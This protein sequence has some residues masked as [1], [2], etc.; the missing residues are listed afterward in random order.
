MTNGAGGGRFIWHDLMTTDEDAAVQFY[1][2][3]TGWGTETWQGP[4]QYTMWTAKGTPVG[5]VMKQPAGTGAPPHWIGYVS[6]PNVDETTAK[7][8]RLGG[9][10]LVKPADIPEVGRFAVLADPQGAAIAV[11]RPSREQAPPAGPPRPG[12]F[13]WH[14]LATTSQP[15]ATKFYESLFGWNG[16]SDMDMGDM[17]VYAMFGL[18]EEPFGGIFKKPAEMPGPPNWLHYIHVDDVKRV[19]DVVTANGGQVLNGPMEV[20]GGDWIAQCMD[21]QGGMFAIHSLNPSASH[22]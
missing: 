7:A 2:K 14:E 16:T 5:G 19:V 17:G 13:S 18:G 3:V 6:T 22:A 12:E 1:T 4:T 11:Y 21:P 9:R 10:V 8:E 20:P 15:D